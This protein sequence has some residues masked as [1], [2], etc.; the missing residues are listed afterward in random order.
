MPDTRRNDA[1]IGSNTPRR[2]ASVTGMRS[3]SGGGA[4]SIEDSLTLPPASVIRIVSVFFAL[5]VLAM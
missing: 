1:V 5:V 2:C 3:S 4:G